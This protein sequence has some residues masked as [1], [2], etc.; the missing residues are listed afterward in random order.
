MKKIEAYKLTDGRIVQSKDEAERLQNEIDFKGSID[1][2]LGKYDIYDTDVRDVMF[3][4]RYEFKKAF[5]NLK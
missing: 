2:L 4:Y 5:E 3:A 1:N